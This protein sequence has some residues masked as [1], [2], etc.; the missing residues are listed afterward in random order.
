MGLLDALPGNDGNGLLN[1]LPSW[2][3]YQTP[4]AKADQERQ[5]VIDAA[6]R[7]TMGAPLP[8]VSLPTTPVSASP[9]VP[10]A[11]A[12]PA[13][14]PAA[15]PLPFSG[16]SAG[17][18][19]GALVPTPPAQPMTSAPPLPP[20]Q[21]IA[22]APQVGGRRRPGNAGGPA[23]PAMS[24]APAGTLSADPAPP[25]TSTQ[26]PLSDFFNRLAGGLQS[27]AHGGSLA[28]AIRGHYDDSASQQAQAQNLTA[29]AL[30]ARGIDPQAV[31]AAIQPGNSEL[32]KKLIAQAYGPQLVQSIGSGLS[33]GQSVTH[34]G[35]TIATAR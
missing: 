12:R 6:Q 15:A 24:V 16:G 13:D 2:W 18:S 33:P 4:E 34:S 10:P 1:G 9:P 21:T 35:A 32:L 31:T 20:P 30:L 8:D 29:K 22:A 27:V 26:G 14:R 3:Q 19:T 7:M 28:G 5:R 23:D 17:W 11:L 25:Q